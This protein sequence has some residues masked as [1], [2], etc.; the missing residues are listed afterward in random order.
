MA[1]PTPSQ[2]AILV[3]LASHAK[4]KA[5][6]AADRISKLGDTPVEYQAI[7]IG[8]SSGLFCDI[9]ATIADVYPAGSVQR[10]TMI[11]MLT[12]MILVLEEKT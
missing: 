11:N 2:E 6:D 10:T 3:D 8:A 5:F 1:A 9:I 4:Q 12:S 7:M